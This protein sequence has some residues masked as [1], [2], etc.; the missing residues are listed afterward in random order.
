MNPVKL[1]FDQYQRYRVIKDAIDAVRTNK[2]PLK[3][4][5]VGGSPGTLLD[6]LPDDDIYTV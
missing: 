4:L 6:F 1:P 3:I 5:D 2:G